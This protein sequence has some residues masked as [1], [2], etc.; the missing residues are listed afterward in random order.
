M[1]NPAMK[2]W[3]YRNYYLHSFA[4]N[5]ILFMAN[6]IINNTPSGPGHWCLDRLFLWLQASLSALVLF[7]FSH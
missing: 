7:S 6:Q 5:E 4:F 1:T 2:P 3:L